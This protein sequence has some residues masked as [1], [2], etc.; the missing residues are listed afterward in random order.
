MPSSHHS[1]SI[2]ASR[3]IAAS[4]AAAATSSTC[5]N[6]PTADAHSARDPTTDEGS[7]TVPNEA[8]A[9]SAAARTSPGPTDTVLTPLTL[10][11]CSICYRKPSGDH[12][13]GPRPDDPIRLSDSHTHD[14]VSE[15]DGA[16]EP[17]VVPAPLANAITE[18]AIICTA[19]ADSS[20]PAIRVRSTIPL[21]LS[22]RASGDAKRNTR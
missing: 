21:S 2:A 10:L 7:S 4:C 22:S 17:Q 12:R 13:Q 11:H 18:S 1:G 14:A 16:R 5:C 19:I 6:D 9:A 3:T 8:T 15:Q 20:N